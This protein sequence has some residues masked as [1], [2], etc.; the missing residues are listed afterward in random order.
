MPDSTARIQNH[1]KACFYICLVI[2]ISDW[3]GP[4]LALLATYMWLL[5]WSLGFL[6]TWGWIA[7]P[8]SHRERDSKKLFHLLKPSLG[9]HAAAILPR[10]ST[11]GGIHKGFPGSRKR[12]QTPRHGRMAVFWKSEWDQKY[13]SQKENAI[14]CTWTNFLTSLNLCFLILKLE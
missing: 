12:K 3:L 9:S 4:K 5:H 1:Q 7:R 11:C 14:C 2:D 13:C 6:T 10:H 8:R